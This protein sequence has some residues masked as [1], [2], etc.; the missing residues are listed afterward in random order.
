M[1]GPQMFAEENADQTTDGTMQGN[2][3]L[4]RRC[5]QRGTQM[6]GKTDKEEWTRVGANVRAPVPIWCLVFIGVIL[7]PSADKSPFLVCRERRT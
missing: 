6:K 3:C 4:V 2:K 7:R 5:S 1:L